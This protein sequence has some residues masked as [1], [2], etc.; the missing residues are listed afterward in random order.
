MDFDGEYSCELWLRRRQP[1][2]PG[3]LCGDESDCEG[4]I[5][6]NIV[7]KSNQETTSKVNESPDVPSCDIEKHEHDV[8][9]ESNQETTSKVNE[10]T[11]PESPT[12]P[13]VFNWRR[14]TPSEVEASESRWLDCDSDSDVSV[15]ILPEVIDLVSDNEAEWMPVITDVTNLAED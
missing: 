11:S 13:C 14:M 7:D 4:D 5:N 8:T 6:N 2:T 9:P 10:M 3:C 12:D 1:S 15:E